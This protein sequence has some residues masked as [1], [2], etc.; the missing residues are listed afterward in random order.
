MA[1]PK[2]PYLKKAHEQHEYSIDHIE[3]L[4]KCAEDPIYFIKHYCQIQHPTKGSIPFDLY[5]YQERMIRAF[6]EH[7]L[8]ITLASRQVGKSQCSAAY[9]LWYAMFNFEK[10]VLI[11]A[12]KNDLAMETI[13]RIRFMYEH[14]PHWI[15]PGLTEDGWNKHNIGFD[16]GSRI[17]STATSENAGRGM[18]ISLLMLDEFAFVRDTVQ[19]EFWTSMSPTLATGGSCIIA[20]TPNGDSNLFAQLWRGAN[21]PVSANE[22]IG[23][24][25]FVP[26]HIK[27]DEPPGRDEEFK[28]KE[29]AK[30]GELKWLQEF[31]T[32]FITTDPVLFNTIVMAN[33]TE[34]VKNLKIHGVISDVVFFKPPIPHSVYI[35]GMDPA[36]GSGEDY[37]AIEV[38]E[39]PSMEQAAEWRSNTMS[40][41]QAYHMLKKVINIYEKIQST[42]YF[43]VENNGVGEAI[44][45]LYEADENP[46]M[47]AE[48]V[49]EPGA[50][51]VGMTTTGK[52]KI[53]SC[54]AFKEMVERASIYIRSKVLVEEMKQYVRKGGSY[55][56]K[57]GST[58]DSISACLIVIRVLEEI[59]TFDQDAY[60]KLYAHAYL[61]D[62]T[63]EQWSDNDVG[64][65]MLF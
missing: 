16:N 19:E 3:E 55:I 31:E 33:L 40:S 35:L 7:Q 15:K 21:I 20:S 6:H 38:F 32:K 57:T 14:L 10:T 1:K 41:V 26:I 58:D 60:A 44:V 36:T 56:A 29:I 9:I 8:V 43:S 12:N 17:I 34:E 5:P 2:N 11:A 24:N 30:I 25:G 27:W 59:A 22:I 49:S 50:K 46:P 61:P 63:E 62:D 4:K 48:F 65:P 52:S 53:K 39:F 23:T 42:V 37:T 13:Y 28:K 18:S 51:R 47:V 54:L 64:M 45:A